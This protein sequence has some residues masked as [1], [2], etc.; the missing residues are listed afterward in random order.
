MRDKRPVPLTETGCYKVFAVGCLILALVSV[1][2][3]I[4]IIVGAAMHMSGAG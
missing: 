1:L 4:A 3:C 2:V